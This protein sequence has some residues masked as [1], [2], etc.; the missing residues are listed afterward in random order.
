MDKALLDFVAEVGEN[1][2]MTGHSKI[3]Q[4]FR[5]PKYLR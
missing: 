5:V 4:Y 1:A 2:A 3:L